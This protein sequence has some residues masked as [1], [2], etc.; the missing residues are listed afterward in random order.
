M[1]S[2]HLPGTF[3]ITRKQCLPNYVSS[4]WAC[5]TWVPCL[6]WWLLWNDQTSGLTHP[7]WLALWG[8]NTAKI[9]Y[10]LWWNCKWQ[11]QSA[12]YLDPWPWN[13]RRATRQQHRTQDRPWRCKWHR[14]SARQLRFKWGRNCRCYGPICNRTRWWRTIPQPKQWTTSQ[15]K[16]K[17]G[18]AHGNSQCAS[19]GG[20]ALGNNKVKIWMDNQANNKEWLKAMSKLEW[21]RIIT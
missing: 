17:G 11:A 18:I 16:S 15:C 4:H 20:I 1:Q 12:Q 9:C 5:I 6:I 13:H 14:P 3:T 21:E 7:V 2:W 19:K 10:I 8:Q